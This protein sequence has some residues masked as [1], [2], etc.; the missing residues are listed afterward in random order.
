VRPEFVYRH[1]WQPHDMVFWDNRSVMH[2]AA[3]TPDHLRRKLYRTTI[4]GDAVLSAAAPKSFSKYK[5]DF[6]PSIFFP[7]RPDAP[8]LGALAA[9]IALLATGPLRHAAHA[10]ARCASPNSSAS[11]TCC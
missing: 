3:G 10:E 9:S 7:A 2:L 6:M 1:T 4:E 11:S 5:V 8:P